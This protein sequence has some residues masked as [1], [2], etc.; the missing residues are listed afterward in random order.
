MSLKKFIKQ[1]SPDWLFLLLR[2]GYRTIKSPYNL[3]RKAKRNAQFKRKLPEIIARAEKLRPYYRDELSRLILSDC[4][5]YLLTHDQNIFINRAVKQGWSFPELF[6]D[7]DNSGYISPKNFSDILIIYDD[8]N[9]PELKYTCTLLDLSNWEKKYRLLNFSEASKIIIKNCEEIRNNELIILV[10]SKKHLHKIIGYM[11]DK[12]FLFKHSVYSKKLSATRIDLQY[13]DVFDPVDDEIII[14][15]G[16]YDGTTAKQFLQWGGG[17]VKKIYSFEFDPFNAAKCEENLKDLRDKVTLIKKGT[18][19]KDEMSYIIASGD[20]IS[21][22]LNKGDDT[23]EAVYLT[24]IDSVVKDERVTFIKMDIE[25]AE[26]KS[27]IGAKN[28]II[29]NKPRLAICLYHK[30]EDICEI[31]E[32]IL[33]LVPEYKFYLR[34]YNSDMGETV[35]YASCD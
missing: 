10:M 24:K 9:N 34:H 33:S 14:D 27:L 1:N 15:A 21:S 26:L 17:K 8:E 23:H 3:I 19:D 2:T 4:E 30:P 22:L 25:G 28:T 13:F 7:I 29:K 32:Y 11:C 35:L 20:S 12:N 6:S 31:P 18:W 16:C 5:K